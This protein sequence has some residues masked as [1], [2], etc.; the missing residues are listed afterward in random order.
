MGRGVRSSVGVSVGNPG[1]P[2]GVLE[3]QYVQPDAVPSDCLAFLTALA[4][5]LGEAIQSRET[6]E[7]VRRQGESLAVLTESLRKLVGDRER[8]VEQIP[9]VVL[10]CDLYADGSGTFVFVSSASEPILGV[11]GVGSSRGYDP[12]PQLRARRRP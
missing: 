4:N 8:L 1:S 9:G 3:V 10:V 7:L 2:V 6:Q 11:P 5:V 12:L